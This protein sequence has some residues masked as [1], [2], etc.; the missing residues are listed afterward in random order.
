[1]SISSRGAGGDDPALVHDHEAV[2]ELLGLVHVVGG[3]QDRHA[4]LLELEQALPHQVAGLRV[5]AGGGL[6]EEDQVGL[7]DQGPGDGQAALHAAGEVVD[8]VVRAA[9]E[10]HELEQFGRAGPGLAPLDA[11]VPG[12]DG[13][14]LEDRE[15][16][17]EGVVLRHDAEAGADGRP[18][19]ARVE[20][21]DLDLAAGG[22]GDAADHP[23]GGGLAGAVGAEEAEC[24]SSPDLEVDPLTASN[25]P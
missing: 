24:L 11:E 5:Q 16:V 22:L 18:V 13:E 12:V 15:H 6:V 10:L 19:A 7:V 3:Q 20:A 9:R 17:V 2:A 25:S 4:L 14:V 21:E 1:M 23:H 8:L